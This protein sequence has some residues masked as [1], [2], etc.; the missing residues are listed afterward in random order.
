MARD[1]RGIP[2]STL[3]EPDAVDFTFRLRNMLSEIDQWARDQSFAMGRIERGQV[4]N[5]SGDPLPGGSGL[6]LP[7]DVGAVLFID[8]GPSL[9]SDGD[10]FFWDTANSVLGIGT[11]TPAANLHV[12]ALG[13]SVYAYPVATP[14]GVGFWLNNLGTSANL[15]EYV[16]DPITPDDATYLSQN[17][18]GGSLVFNLTSL[19][20]PSAGSTHTLSIRARVDDVGAVSTFNWTLSSNGNTVAS[21]S[22]LTLGA[23][24]ATIT[25]VLT[26]SEVA[27][28]THYNFLTLGLSSSGVAGDNYFV[29]WCEL[30]ITTSD[31]DL[32]RWDLY[33]GTESGRISPTG[34]M[35]IGTSSDSLTS[36]MLT[37]ES[38]SAATVGELIKGATSQSGNLLEFRNSADTL[39]SRFT[40]AG[41]LDG[42]IDNSTS[43]ASALFTGAVTFTGASN[44][45]ESPKI[46][47]NVGGFTGFGLLLDDGG[48]FLGEIQT[49]G[50]TADRTWAFP[51]ASGT[52]VL[53][54]VA[55]TIAGNTS[56]TLVSSTSGVGASFI[57][58]TT[59]SKRLR[60]VLSGATGANAFVF[61]T[62]AARLWGFGNLSG[63]VNITGDDP[64]AVAAGALGKVDLT[65]QTAG[66]G[67]T[68][69]SNTPPAGLYRVDV[70]VATTT[71]SGS[72]TP[73]LDVN[74][75]WTDVLGATNQNCVKEPSNATGFPHSLSATGRTSATMF[76]QVAS[77]NIAYTTTITGASGSPQYAIYIRVTYLG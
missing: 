22:G 24:F 47:V 21:D 17:G 19:S 10:V 34:H 42:P 16:D 58:T 7:D 72:G 2:F 61:T 43:Q 73:T 27:L 66:I 30:A 63:F 5:G 70:Y 12:E 49:A 74:I 65:G 54:G 1:F 53:T 75:A 48:G 4:P 40:S 45:A 15:W 56:T 64:P 68:N 3:P 57:D 38:D 59:S 69:L 60:M 37:V 67:S 23:G 39:L 62:S 77:G 52:F 25:H 20:T 8:S 13:Q 11:N 51:D 33:G 55:A 44:S 29:S 9:G 28:I 76:I 32:I 18:V 41:K 35:G 26:P 6:E 36:N 14:F 71:A 46:L 31:A 50:L